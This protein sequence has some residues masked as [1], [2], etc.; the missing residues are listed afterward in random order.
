MC[1]ITQALHEAIKNS[2]HSYQSLASLLGMS[3]ASFSQRK[4]GTVPWTLPEVFQ[5]MDILEIPKSEIALYFKGGT[6]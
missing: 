3:P 6:K 1:T 4:A 2:G 5:I